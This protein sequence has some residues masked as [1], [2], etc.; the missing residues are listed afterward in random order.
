MFFQRL[1][2][3]S[4]TPPHTQTV[5][6]TYFTS[7]S[8]LLATIFH[9]L[10]CNLNFNISWPKYQSVNVLQYTPLL[11]WSRAKKCTHLSQPI[12]L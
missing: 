8:P 2:T 1:S 7:L 3:I 5:V 10:I 11:R 6:V 12:L 4:K 9:R